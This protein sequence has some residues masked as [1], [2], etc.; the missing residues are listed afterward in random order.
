VAK[1]LGRNC[2]LLIESATPGTFNAISGNV[3]LSVSRSSDTIDTSTKDDFPYGSQAS[4]LQK[5]SIT[6]TFRPD[7]PDA[8]GYDRLVT[9]I[10]T[11]NPFNVQIKDGATVVFQG[12]VYSTARGN[13]LN[14]NDPGE[15]SLTLVAA[16]APTTDLL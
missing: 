6:A 10:G 13:D 3:N 15:V 16:A 8:N 5:V 9:Q 14:V 7:L 11:G 1:R 2:K 12:S 4:G